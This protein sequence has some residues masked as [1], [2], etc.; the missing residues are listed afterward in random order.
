MRINRPNGSGE[1]VE[2]GETACSRV[3]GLH[4]FAGHQVGTELV[5]QKKQWQ[6]D[7]P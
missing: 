1:F 4:V 5:C 2:D 7:S 6:E 3:G